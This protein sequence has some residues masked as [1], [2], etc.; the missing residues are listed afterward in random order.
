MCSMKL[1]TLACC[2]AIAGTMS[3]QAEEIKDTRTLVELPSD[4]KE[5]MMVIMRDHIRALDDIIDAVQTG[6]YDKAESIVESRLSWS[7]PLGYEDQEV[8][9]YWPEAMQKMAN[10]L[11][12]AA[13]NY[14]VVSRNA[15]VE[16]SKESYKKI[17][18]AL[19]ELSS[20]C[21]ACHEA[22]RLR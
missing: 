19:G 8:I 10:Q 18:T 3:L 9:K 2:I 7:S 1:I 5:K 17:N 4:I 21:R 12:N 11:Y 14:V 20:A 16:E 22:Y 15:A 13:T 6:K